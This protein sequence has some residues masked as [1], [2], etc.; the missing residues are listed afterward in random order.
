MNFQEFQEKVLSW[1]DQ[2]FG[3]E[4]SMDKEERNFRF[5]EE[6]T[7][8]VQSL[9]MTKEDAIKVVLYVYARDI[10]EPEQEVGGTLLTLAA[11]GNANGFD[12]FSCGE[13]ELERVW[14]KIEKIREKQKNKPRNSPLA[15][16]QS[17]PMIE[18]IEEKDREIE[19]LKN[20]LKIYEDNVNLLSSTWSN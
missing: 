16:T 13:I 19:E 2:C 1:T 11:L 8:L 4:I 12:I 15:E 10:G 7:E 20:K 6:A 3:N 5:L 17:N 18:L 9:N 14:Q